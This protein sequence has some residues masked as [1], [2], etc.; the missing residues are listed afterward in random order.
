MFWDI[1]LEVWPQPTRPQMHWKWTNIHTLR[2]W[3]WA[4]KMWLQNEKKW[5]EGGHS[6]SPEMQWQLLALC[7]G[8]GYLQ[9][10]TLADWLAILLAGWLPL[11][12]WLPGTGWLTALLALCSHALLIHPEPKLEKNDQGPLVLVFHPRNAYTDSYSLLKHLIILIATEWM[13]FDACLQSV[14]SA[15]QASHK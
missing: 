9:K 5:T 3:R 6:A 12:C 14:P 1:A 13:I 7:C 2:V 15:K 11:P 4:G 8:G 10:V